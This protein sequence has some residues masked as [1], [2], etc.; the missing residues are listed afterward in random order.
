MR[1]TICLTAALALCACS[2]PATETANTD[3]NVAV[4]NSAATDMNAAVDAN[5]ATPAAFQLNETTW[6][7]TDKKGTKVKESIDATGNYIANSEDGKKHIDHGTGVM[8][9]GK[10]CFTS[11]MD[12]SGEVCWTT[13]PTAIGETLDTTS[14]K[15]EKLAVTRVAYEALTIPK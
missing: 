8:K 1:L 12:K 10:A 9:D 3:T 7:F 5:A 15:G 2:K 14:D 4:D 11:A 6:T 13:K